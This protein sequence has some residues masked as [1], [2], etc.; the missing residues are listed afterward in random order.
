MPGTGGGEQV[1]GPGE[2]P[3]LPVEDQELIELAV[4]RDS[5]PQTFRA[6]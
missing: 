5:G 4:A 6:Q 2:E 3:L 1:P